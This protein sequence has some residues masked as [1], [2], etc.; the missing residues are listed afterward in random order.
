MTP[1]RPIPAP[2]PGEGGGDGVTIGCCMAKVLV[3]DDEDVLV[4]LIASLLDD[5]GHEAVT[6]TNG[7]EALAALAA[8]PIP[9]ALI[10]TDVMMPLM[11]GVELARRVR[12]DD[13]L[14]S[15]PIILM[16]AAGRPSPEGVTS[17]FIQKPFDVDHLLEV[18]EHCINDGNA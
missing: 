9:P 18:V 7:R 10:V 3:V 14:A 15:I 2:F 1:L 11:T 13:R 4:A 16:S 12:Q 8:D 5:I 6:A 17:Y